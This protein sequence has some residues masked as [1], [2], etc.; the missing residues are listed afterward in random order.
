MSGDPDIEETSREAIARLEARIEELAEDLERCRKIGIFSNVL[1]AGGAVWLIAGL[2]GIVSMRP[3]MMGSIAAILGGLV[4]NG[5]NRSSAQQAQAA[6]DAAEASRIG[7][8]GAIDMRTV[9]GR[10]E[11]GPSAPVRWLH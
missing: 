7:L 5:S 2:L 1:L 11:A 10:V 6:L 4:L 9:D 3:A 8:I